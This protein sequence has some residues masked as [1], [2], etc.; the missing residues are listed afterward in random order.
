MRKVLPSRYNYFVDRSDGVMAFNARTGTFALL[1]PDVANRLRMGLLEESDVE[2]ESLL[3]MGFVHRGDEFEKI[4]ALY[5]GVTEEE[6]VLGITLVPSLS[7]N[8][9]CSY[10]YQTAYKTERRNDA[11]DQS[12]VL[13]YIRARLTENWRS[14][15]CTWYGGEPLLS[16]EIVIDMSRKI[17]KMAD[18]SG[19]TLL[20]MSIV[21]NGVLLTREVAKNLSHVG[22]QV[23]QVSFD[24]F[25]D[26][27]DAKR[28]CHA[29]RVTIRYIK[30]CNYGTGISES[31]DT[32]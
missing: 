7:C 8:R 32:H 9:T 30:Q 20:P 31:K 29:E 19:V 21:T 14:L 18:E 11:G 25:F 22:F 24:S 16:K 17:K 15:N 26:D 12:G 13:D 28:G 2:F 27:G 23:A 3:E 10:C 4:V 5:E 6:R 1:S